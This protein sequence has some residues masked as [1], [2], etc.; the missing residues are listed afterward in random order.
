MSPTEPV[1][2]AVPPAA[3]SG[4][5]VRRRRAWARSHAY[6]LFSSLGRFARAPLNH[7]LTLG[8]IAVA[9]ALPTL[10]L[11]LLGNVQ[12]LG[13]GMAQTGDVN[14][15]LKPEIESAAA[16][17][18]AQ[19][20]R[21]AAEVQELALKSPEAALAEFKDLADFSD[22]LIALDANPLPFVL[23]I[24]LTR[25][26]SA[27]A[28][29]RDF[30]A[31]MRAL[32]EVE[33]V[34]FD[35]EWLAR[36]KALIGLVERGVLVVGALLGLAVLL[37]IGNTIRLEILTRR[38]EIVIMKLVGADDAFIRRP[39]LYGGLWFGLLG[40]A[41]ALTLVALALLLLKPAVQELS[42]A[43]GSG[44][45]LAGLGWITVTEVLGLGI[46]LGCTG[47]WAASRRHLAE[48]EPT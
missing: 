45:Q 47:A 34:Q 28:A 40:A 5:Q 39:F 4:V 10:S 36:L 35:Q 26:A 9:L 30:V 31:R 42:M 22:A 21:T 18:L 2:V 25:A 6:S 8:V 37:V 17:Q 48:A 24:E 12:R 43:Y 27:E 15:F 1:A 41:L 19:R 3:Q 33:L 29:A 46:L 32:P 38:D 20:L 13:A 11:V 7:L 16:E 23:A 14:L 44:F